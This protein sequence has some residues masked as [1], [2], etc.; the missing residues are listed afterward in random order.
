MS[1]T[2]DSCKELGESKLD[3]DDVCEVKD[4]LQNL[5]TGDVDVA[6]SVCANCGKEGDDINNICNKCKQ[7]RYCNAA[8]KKKHRSKHKKDCE[9][10]IRLATEK[11]NEELRIAAELHDIEL[12]KQPPP[13][14]DCP[15]CFVH[16]P[17]MQTGSKYMTCCG[18]MIC[19]G[20][21]HA[22]VYDNQ[23]NVVEDKCPFCRTP[24][25]TSNEAVERLKKRLKS[26]DPIAICNHGNYYRDG[27]NGFAQ[28]HTKALELW[29]RAAKLGCAGAYCSI[30]Y[31]YENGH[32]VE[33]DKKKALHYYEQAAMR[34]D[35]SARHY[36][37]YKEGMAGNFDRAV[38]HYMVAVRCG[39]NESLEA[40][41]L[42]YSNGYATKD[43][44]TKALQ[45]YQVYLGDIKSNQRDRAASADE[46]NR[47]Y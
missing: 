23:G 19:S 44:Y 12:F 42:L 20:C 11:H 17:T 16:I 22:P 39:Q 6:V 29:H 21:I 34:G 5:N 43:D 27:M 41:K 30:G 9:E 35:E 13:P 28:N 47:Y 4:M 31:A 1:D 37:G 45:A 18:K 26:D 24:T 10:H 3:Y 36:L 32:G 15:I 46:R 8:C 33:V 2:S 38:K 14:E 7:V 25:P 40:I